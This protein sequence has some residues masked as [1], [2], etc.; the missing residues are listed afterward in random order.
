[1]ATMT[2]TGAAAASDPDAGDE[3][4]NLSPEEISALR[5]EK[6]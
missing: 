3:E 5:Y 2:T 6:S 1:M 4:M